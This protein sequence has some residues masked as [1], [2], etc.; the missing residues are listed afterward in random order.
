M[1]KENLQKDV[2]IYGLYVIRNKVTNLSSSI[3]REANDRDGVAMAVNKIKEALKNEPNTTDTLDVF[4]LIRVGS[5]D[6]L[7][8][9]I[10]DCKR[11]LIELKEE[12][13]NN[14]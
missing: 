13:V 1:S 12:V 7:S 14:G 9:T 2:N 10:V 11:Y 5:Y 3:C 4:E 8:Q 6:I